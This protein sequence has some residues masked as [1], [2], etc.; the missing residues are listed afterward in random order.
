MKKT[1]EWLKI[2]AVQPPSCNNESNGGRLVKMFDNSSIYRLLD[3]FW[4]E[5]DEDY[6]KE[7]WVDQSDSDPQLNLSQVLIRME[8]V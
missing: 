7:T 4:L 2:Y 1:C 5:L 6:E 8:N 3:S